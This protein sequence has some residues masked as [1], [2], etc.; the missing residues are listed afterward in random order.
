[1]LAGAGAV[2][3]FFLKWPANYAGLGAFV[4]AWLAARVSRALNLADAIDCRSSLRS[5]GHLRFAPTGN[6][7]MPHFRRSQDTLA[8]AQGSR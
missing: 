8:H 5:T 7:S 4:L 1:M 3:F 6:S 2:G